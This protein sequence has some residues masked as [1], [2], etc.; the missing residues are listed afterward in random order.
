MQL[1]KRPAVYGLKEREQLLSSCRWNTLPE[2]MP[3][4]STKK[5]DIN[6]NQSLSS[7]IASPIM[8]DRIT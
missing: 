1:S 3:Q 5:R 8:G 6:V 7:E 4:P 2:A